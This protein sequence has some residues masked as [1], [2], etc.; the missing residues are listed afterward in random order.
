[1]CAVKLTMCAYHNGVDYV[2]KFSTPTNGFYIILK[3]SSPMT[4]KEEDFEV[5]FYIYI[6]V[7]L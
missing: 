2:I 7:Q 3:L 6:G 1:M 4:K 5:I